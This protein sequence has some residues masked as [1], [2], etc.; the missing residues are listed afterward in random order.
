MFGPAT[1]ANP[2]E[3]TTIQKNSACR[4]FALWNPL[5]RALQFVYFRACAGLFRCKIP[6]DFENVRACGGC[7]IPLWEYN[8]KIFAPAAAICDEKSPYGIEKFHA[9]GGLFAVQ[10][11]LVRVQF[12]FFAPAAAISDEKSLYGSSTFENFVRLRRPICDATS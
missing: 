6:Y 9:C 2:H 5:M 1:C 8:L 4:L 3:S 7:K 11:P 10:N 12:V